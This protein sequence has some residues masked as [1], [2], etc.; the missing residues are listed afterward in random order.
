MV[1][2]VAKSIRRTVAPRSGAVIPAAAALASRITP[3]RQVSAPRGSGDMENRSR[4]AS[5]RGGSPPSMAVTS[6]KTFT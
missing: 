6:P 3:E 4:P 2:P 5:A 1:A